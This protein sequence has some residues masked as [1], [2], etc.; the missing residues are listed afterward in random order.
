M[1][2]QGR[3]CQ[4]RGQPVVSLDAQQKALV[5]DCAHK[6]QAWQPQGTPEAVG[7]HACPDPDLGKAMP[8][9][10]YDMT[11]NHGWVSVGIDHDTAQ[12]APAPLR[13]WWQAMGCQM[14]P[15]AETRV[16]TADSGGSNRRRSRLW[17]G[18]LQAVA[19]AIGLPISVGHF[20]PGT[21]KWQKIAQRMFGHITE[22]W[23]GRPL[24]SLAVMVTL[25]GHTTTTT[26][27]QMQAELDT[28]PYPTGLKVSA[29][30]LAAVQITKA[31]FHGEWNYTISPR[32]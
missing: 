20:P 10:V 24:R 4:P 28:H 15:Q 17:Q 5:G 18:A 27:L 6:G 7:T 26:G 25:M 13:R 23:R 21:S 3:A 14:S 32:G 29:K 9:G 8:S 19:D 2:A 12:C 31:S 30:E 16:V 1:N 22:N 11:P